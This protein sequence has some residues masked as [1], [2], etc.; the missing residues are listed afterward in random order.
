MREGIR[1]NKRRGGREKGKRGML[2]II[3]KLVENVLTFAFEDARQIYPFKENCLKRRE[4]IG[5]F[6]T[7]VWKNTV[8][9]EHPTCLSLL[10]T[11]KLETTGLP[12]RSLS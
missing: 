5:T 12:A 2:A 4:S 3:N 10:V 8:P 1:D 9:R 7:T 6:S 11:P